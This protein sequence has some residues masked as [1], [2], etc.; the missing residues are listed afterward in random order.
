MNDEEVSKKFILEKTIEYQFSLI[1]RRWQYFATYLLVNGLLFNAWS[2]LNIVASPIIQSADSDIFTLLI[3]I[4]NIITGAVFL[5]LIS[6]SYFRINRSQ[7]RL[8]EAGI[9]IFHFNP[10]GV[11]FRKSETLMLYFAVLALSAGWFYLV[12]ITS[13]E[14][15]VVGI[16][17][18]I[19]NL[20]ALKWRSKSQ[21]ILLK[22][23][24]E[25][26]DDVSVPAIS[27]S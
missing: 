21:V 4:A 5:Q 20:F 8:V 13:Y 6:L 11:F 9:D 10:T 17:F 18:F 16:I 27:G 1:A 12:Y 2:S 15:F 14:I 23:N 7:E 25:E 26:S 19:L 24:V 22:P 3:S